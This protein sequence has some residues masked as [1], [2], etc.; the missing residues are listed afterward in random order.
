MTSDL[1]TSC[2]LA[3]LCEYESRGKLDEIRFLI[4][5]RVKELAIPEKEF[6]RKVQKR[7]E[8]EEAD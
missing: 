2:R 7:I 1:V 6:D 8:E 5:N 4:T 3:V